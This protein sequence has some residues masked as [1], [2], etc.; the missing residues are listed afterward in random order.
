MERLDFNETPLCEA[1]I[2]ALSA[3]RSD[4]PAA[5]VRAQL[6]AMVKEA[7]CFLADE[8]Q[9][10]L[11]LERVLTLFYHHWGFGC[12]SAPYTLSE[13]MWL[14]NV[15]STRCGTALSLGII[16]LH[17]T[18][19]LD[20]PLMPVIFPTQ[21]ILRADWF[22]GDKWLIDPSNGESLD[23]RT[24]EAWLKGNINPL[25]NLYEEDMSE[26]RPSAVFQKMLDLLKTA[27]IEEQQ[28]EMALG[29]SQALLLTKPDDPYEIRDRGLIYAQ[30]DCCHV[31]LSDL[32]YFVECCPEDPV[33]EL[34]KL[35][36]KA[37]EKK[38][39]TLH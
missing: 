14:D 13:V 23:E 29:V 3:I 7:R 25:A 15:L 37:I 34:I 12:A 9:P 11:Q 10:D 32:N 26:A 21:L 8:R 28:L 36:I 2:W 18:S 22:D 19:A 24:L 20:I 17:I 33:S 27:L 5:G 4:F 30:L 16:L 31:A 38:R 39:V 1:I 6:T 35:Q